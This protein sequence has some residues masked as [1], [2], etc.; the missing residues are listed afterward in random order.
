MEDIL[1]PDHRPKME[2]FEDKIMLILKMISIDEKGRLQNEQVSIVFGKNY[3]LT[4]QER[5]GDLFDPVRARLEK[6]VGRMRSMKADYLAFALT[7]VIVDNYFVV[8]EAVAEMLEELE[9]T[10]IND[11]ESFRVIDIHDLKMQLFYLRKIAW[12]LRELAQGLLKTESEL[13][14][15]PSRI[16]FGDLYDH[17]VRILETTETLREVSIGVSE[18]YRSNI[19]LKMNEIMQTLTIISTIFIPMTFIAGVYGMNFE[20]MP[21]LKWQYGYFGVMGIMLL[22]ALAMLMFFRRKR[23]F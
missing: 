22:V 19:S 3:V 12:P 18:L 23:W 13:V 21:E 17:T 4:F 11:P 6:S 10:L 16:Y 14:R 15:K 2:V 9:M 20:N 7:D 8:L 1:N 5:P